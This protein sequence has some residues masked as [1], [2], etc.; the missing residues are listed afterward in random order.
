MGKI[1][2]R[3]VALCVYLMP[4]NRPLTVVYVVTIMLRVIY[5]NKHPLV[6]CICSE[7]TSQCHDGHV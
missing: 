6:M 1:W 7:F 2:R 4:Q 5:H 3:G